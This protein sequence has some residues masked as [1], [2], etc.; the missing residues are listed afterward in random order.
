[1]PWRSSE[2]SRTCSSQA[3]HGFGF[4]DKKLGLGKRAPSFWGVWGLG[5]GILGSSFVFF[6]CSFVLKGPLAGVIEIVDV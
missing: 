6:G 4:Q 1:M 2:S 5:F 3:F